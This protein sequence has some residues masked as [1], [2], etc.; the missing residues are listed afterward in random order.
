MT[1]KADVRWVTNL[2]ITHAATVL[3]WT[4]GSTSPS[5]SKSKNRIDGY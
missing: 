1:E 3:N 4:R 2:F 5:I